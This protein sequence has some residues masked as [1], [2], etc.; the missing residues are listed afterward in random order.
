M[1]EGNNQLL[2]DFCRARQRYQ[3]RQ[4]RT[5]EERSE[6][7]E[8]YKSVLSLLTESMRRTGQRCIRCVH[9]ENGSTVYVRLIEG[10]RRAAVMRTP[11]DVLSLVDDVASNVTHVT[12]EDLPDAI[13]RL[14]EARAR[15]TGT[16]VPPRVAVVP[17]VGL[18]ET[19]VEQTNA[20]RE[21]QTLTAQMA[22]NHAE[23]KRLRDEMTPMR[24]ELK[25]VERR[26][27]DT[28]SSTG[29][30]GGGDVAELDQVVQMSTPAANGTVATKTVSVTTVVRPRKRN[31][32]GLR[33]VCRCVREAVSNVRERDETFDQRLRDELRRVLER[34]RETSQEWTRAVVVKRQPRARTTTVQRA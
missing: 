11:E 14:V 23:R 24:R 6:V 12:L 27:C 22:Q 21:L 18:R 33:N 32:Y 19:I 3:E 29:D 30:D 16:D 28:V 20:P 1:A 10:R 8:T 2:V 4:R 34:E 26:L 25:T 13:S 5:A 15:A 7:H 17:R 9:D 31:I